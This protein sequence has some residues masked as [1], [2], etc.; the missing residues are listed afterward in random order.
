MG[1]LII[2]GV[3]ATIGWVAARMLDTQGIGEAKAPDP[4]THRDA[5]VQVYGANVW[6][7]RGRFAIHTWVAT[8]ARDADSY[9]IY[10]VIG[11]RIHRGK[12][13]LSITSGMPDKPWFRSPPILLH[14]QVG[15]GTQ[16]LVEQIH[17]AALRYPY[18]REYTMWPGPNSNSFTT[19]IGLE[20]PQLGLA[21]PHK[22]IGKRWMKTE[23][24]NIPR[25]A[26][27][28]DVLR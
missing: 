9:R 16:T 3:I 6:G 5:V 11:W 10:Q 7:F 15:A 13:A 24:A 12:P 2:V 18:A 28:P 19:W 25:A 22:A 26:I 23:Y 21:L 27:E 17:A 8:K 14:H 20:V 4:I 1:I